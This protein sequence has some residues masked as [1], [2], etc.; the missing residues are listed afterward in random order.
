MSHLKNGLDYLNSR[1]RSDLSFSFARS[2]LALLLAIHAFLA[3][4]E[5]YFNPRFLADDPAAVADLSGFRKRPGGA[6]GYL[7]R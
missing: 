7:S 4:A 1:R 5:L 6:A 3:Q 2:P